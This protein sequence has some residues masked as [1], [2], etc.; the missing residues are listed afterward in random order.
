MLLLLVGKKLVINWL[1]S[2]DLEKSSIEETPD[3]DK[4][5]WKLLKSVDGILVPGSFGDR[6]IAVIEYA[7]SVMNL[8]DANSTKFDL[9]VAT[10]VV[11]FMPEILFGNKMS[12]GALCVFIIEV[13]K[14]K[15]R[16]REGHGNVH[17][18]SKLEATEQKL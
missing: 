10:P 6:E 2:S 9:D 18:S 16:L 8:R 15:M 1:P 4:A 13:L 5:A 17:N 11:V 14:H 3:A 12:L 7:R